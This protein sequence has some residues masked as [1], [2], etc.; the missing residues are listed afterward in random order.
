M[1]M[2]WW[3]EHTR[4]F[5]VRVRGLCWTGFSKSIVLFIISSVQTQ[6]CGSAPGANQL[7]WNR[8]A[9]Q[10]GCAA[11]ESHARRSV[12]TTAGRTCATFHTTMQTRAFSLTAWVVVTGSRSADCILHQTPG[13]ETELT[14]VS[15]RRMES[16]ATIFTFW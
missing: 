8:C 1:Y 14:S 2:K 6:Q 11:A 13:E 3:D 9:R 16:R 4:V 12:N 15:N 7:T 10:L 5:E